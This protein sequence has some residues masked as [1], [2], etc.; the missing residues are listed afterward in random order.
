[1]AAAAVGA[2]R[3]ALFKDR[4]ALGLLFESLVVRDLRVY[5]QAN[6]ADVYH[7]RDKSKL[8]VDAVVE[9]DDGSWIAVEA[10]LG[11][12]GPV[13][14]AA[15]SLLAL[16]AK[17]DTAVCGPPRALVVVTST[18][19]PYQRDDGVGVVPITALRP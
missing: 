8:E 13:E 4:A 5:A 1:L 11:S 16:R 3:E 7:Y 19:R 12:P 15:E 10:K 9:R 17:V 18:G 2:G 14:A 6:R